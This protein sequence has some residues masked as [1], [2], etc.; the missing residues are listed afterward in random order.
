MERLW[1]EKTICSLFVSGGV[2]YVRG[3]VAADAV[4]DAQS[5]MMI[6]GGGAAA[7][8]MT[9][10]L[11]AVEN[12]KDIGKISPVFPNSSISHI[13]TAA[14]L[15]HH[16]DDKA[17]S[18]GEGD[19]LMTDTNNK[20]SPKRL[21]SP[22]PTSPIVSSPVPIK[23]RFSPIPSPR[24]TYLWSSPVLGVAHVPNHLAPT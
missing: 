9:T 22:T 18:D 20:K 23:L 6:G 1:S 4:V 19:R 24:Q 5:G 10:R 14:T 2:V 8:S 13:V 3:I 16:C 21:C 12:E 15:K 11:V 17:V 7:S